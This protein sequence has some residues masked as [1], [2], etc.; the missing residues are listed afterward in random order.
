MIDNLHSLPTSS[1]HVKQG[2]PKHLLLLKTLYG[3]T[4]EMLNKNF[5]EDK[6]TN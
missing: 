4:D 1:D 5:L 3:M 6:R 2:E